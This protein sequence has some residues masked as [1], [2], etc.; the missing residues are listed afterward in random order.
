MEYNT[1]PSDYYFK[2]VVTERD[3]LLFRSTGNAYEVEPH[4]PQSWEDHCNMRRQWELGKW[5]GLKPQYIDCTK[6]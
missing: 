6:E 4:L 3:Y 1:F 5:Y 2:L